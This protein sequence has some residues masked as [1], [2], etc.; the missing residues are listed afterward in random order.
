MSF[1]KCSYCGELQHSNEVVESTENFFK[2][3]GHVDY[4]YNE[5]DSICP[6]CGIPMDQ[7]SY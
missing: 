6:S 2:A 3:N 4:A 5:G 7:G 1:K